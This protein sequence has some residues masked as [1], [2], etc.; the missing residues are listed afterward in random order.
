MDVIAV[1]GKIGL[2]AHGVF[3]ESAL[4][5]PGLALGVAFHGNPG[6]RQGAHKPRFDRSPPPGKIAIAFRQRP[7][8]MQMIGHHHQRIG[9]K[10]P[11]C[12]GLRISGP[13]QVD[14]IY[15]RSRPPIAQRH[16]E[17]KRTARNGIASI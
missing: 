7:E 9:A 8:G 5:D 13:E 6:R 16:R 3:P 2:I 14:V 4:P 12:L 10:R 17:E 11:F 15:Q 1:S